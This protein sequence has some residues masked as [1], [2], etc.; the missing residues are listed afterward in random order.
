MSQSNQG[1]GSFVPMDTE[2]DE[3][4]Q[5]PST[6]STDN[7]RASSDRATPSGIAPDTFACGEMRRTAFQQRACVRTKRSPS[8]GQAIRTDR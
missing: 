1:S 8:Y 5:V 3:V 7:R 2:N 6:S 4:S